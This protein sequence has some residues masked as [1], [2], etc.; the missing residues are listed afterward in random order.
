MSKRT[1]VE[2][3]ASVCDKGGCWTDGTMTDSGVTANLKGSWHIL[4]LDRHFQGCDARRLGNIADGVAVYPNENNN[5]LRVLELKPK[6]ADY[7]DAAKKLHKSV[8]L[9]R[10]RLPHGFRGLRVDLELH[11]KEM[12]VQTAKL[13]KVIETENTQYGVRAYCD[14]EQV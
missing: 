7:P 10:K 3:R 5:R 4:M 8:P 6:V 11:V 13:R 2:L 12:P 1:E 14:G 9:L